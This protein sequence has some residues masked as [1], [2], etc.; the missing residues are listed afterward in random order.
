MLLKLKLFN[1]DSEK[2]DCEGYIRINHP[3]KIK[4]ML[5][6]HGPHFPDPAMNHCVSN[7]GI[8]ERAGKAGEEGRMIFLKTKLLP[9]LV[10]RF[11]FWIIVFTFTL[12][13]GGCFRKYR[14]TE[15]DIDAY[16]QT[17]GPRPKSHF[18][19]IGKHRLHWVQTL[20]LFGAFPPAVGPGPSVQVLVRSF[21]ASCGLSRSAPKPFV[22]CR[23]SVLHC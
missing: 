17:H 16:Y 23:Y 20:G 7:C 3:K 10:F 8:R 4:K 14:M 21:L 11:L 1:T 12:P 19:N 2:K 6:G 5:S 18:L 22:S 9:C 15:K 13:L